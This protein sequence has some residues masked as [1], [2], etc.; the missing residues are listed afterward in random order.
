MSVARLRGAVVPGTVTI[1]GGGDPDIAS[2]SALLRFNG[3]NG[4]TTFTNAVSNGLTLAARGAGALSTTSPKFGT[5]SL[6][7]PLAVDDG[8]TLT[9]AGS[10]FQ[11]PK[12]FTIEWWLYPIALTNDASMY[13]SNTGDSN[14]LAINIDSSNWNLYLNSGNPEATIAHSL[15]LNAW[16]HCA[17]VRAGSTVTVY[18]GGVA[19]GTATSSVTLG[20]ASPSLHR[21]GSAGSGTSNWRMDEFRVTKGIARYTKNFTPPVSAFPDSADLT[22]PVSYA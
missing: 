13:V 2:V 11:F 5:A 4:S 16:T 3:S 7:V 17:I 1:P 20:Y 12:D 15:T 9:N 6:N 22:L 10:L 8:V 14:Y 21:I 18:V 19:T